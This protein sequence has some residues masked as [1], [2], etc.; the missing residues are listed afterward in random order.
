MG[1]FQVDVEFPADANCNL[2]GMEI[3]LSQ[4]AQSDCKLKLPIYSYHSMHELS[5][6]LAAG[7][8]P[9][10]SYW[11]SADMLW[12]DGKGADGQGPCA[13]DRPGACGKST[14]FSNFSVAAIPGTMC[15][16]KLTNQQP[17][18]PDLVDLVT[19]APAEESTAAATT[20][21]FLA[22]EDT[23]DE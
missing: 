11:N 20:T 17:A 14:K 16:A 5:Q 15:K 3:T 4:A 1:P 7:M 22:T 2:L 8:T 21:T 10:V 9:I 18:E 6:A 19:D 23:A 12:M 13:T